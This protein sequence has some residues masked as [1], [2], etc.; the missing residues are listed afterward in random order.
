MATYYK[1]FAHDV[2]SACVL[3]VL[4]GGS[5][6]LVDLRCELRGGVV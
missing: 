2:C 5:K 6:Y 4:V 3:R 1:R